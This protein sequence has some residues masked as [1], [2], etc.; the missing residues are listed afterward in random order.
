MEGTVERRLAENYE[1]GNT[2]SLF[3]PRD[4]GRLTLILGSPPAMLRLKLT[5]ASWTRVSILYHTSWHCP[6]PSQGE[7]A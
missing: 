1:G 2:T 3:V 5:G 4:G 7:V 6:P